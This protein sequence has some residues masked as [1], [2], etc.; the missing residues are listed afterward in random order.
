MAL[1]LLYAGFNEAT[2]L[3]GGKVIRAAPEKRQHYDQYGY[4]SHR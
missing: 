4:A 1:I 3:T 2:L